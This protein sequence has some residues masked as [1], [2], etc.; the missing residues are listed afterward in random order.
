MV[1]LASSCNKNNPTSDTD[2]MY[3]YLS[4]V[5]NSTEVVSKNES[6]TENSSFENNTVPS[7][8][9][10]S[11]T[12]SL[13][14]SS[15]SRLS[16]GS[17]VEQK[18]QGVI[19]T[20]QNRGLYTP[21]S[22]TLTMYDSV[23]YGVTWNTSVEPAAGVVQICEGASFNVSKIKEFK[24]TSKEYTTINA[25]GGGRINYY[26]SKAIVTGLEAGKTYT[27]RCYDKKAKVASDNFT[28]TVND[29]NAEKF[30]FIY[31]SDSQSQ[32]TTDV[33]PD[34]QGIG[35]GIPF[36]NTIAGI[37]KVGVKPSFYLHGGDIV[38]WSLYESYWKNTIEYN[39]STFAAIPFMAISGNHEGSYRSG[40]DEIF[41]HFHY[42]IP[43]QSTTQ[44]I[45]YSFDYGNTRFIMLDT[46]RLSANALTA[47]QLAWLESTLKSNNKKW[48]I[49][50]MH[51]PMYSVGRY[52]SSANT[53]ALA[54]QEQLTDVFAKYK[55]DLV[56]QA[57]DHVYCKTYPIGQGGTV[58]K[59]INYET[60]NGVK[61]STNNN[62]VVYMM[63]GSAGN[64]TRAVDAA[65]KVGLYE[66]YSG[67][68]PSSWAEIEVDGARLTV[69]VYY[70]NNGK[71]A[72]WE[73]FGIKK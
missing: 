22:I 55:V 71:P 30:K 29:R 20:D 51:N 52:G 64:Q 56:L 3:D 73:S 45:Y 63:A 46:N 5:T 72:I 36:S 33:D 58:N 67:S 8:M 50:A 23:S 66:E 40:K 44:G 19:I 31:F 10:S 24:A 35:S 42:D 13:D 49:V 54:L 14:E 62:G 37:S 1:L 68:Q 17:I 39:K 32:T 60:Y 16:G 12:A 43:L 15:S 65:A 59:N 61:Y 47:D 28:F 53:I 7:G 21:V 48:T 11:D 38:E 9:E 70:Y 34:N 25:V 26:V 18:P 4:S 41:K 27:Y 2:S 57:H 6:T 69:K